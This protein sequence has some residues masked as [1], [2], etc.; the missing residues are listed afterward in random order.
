MN[1]ENFS[2][3]GFG[4]NLLLLK[5]INMG[6]TN[7]KL[8]PYV[9]FK[10]NLGNLNN[11]NLVLSF[12]KNNI[13][14]FNTFKKGYIGKVLYS[15]K[16]PPQK[17]YYKA[18]SKF[19]ITQHG[20]F[21]NF[22]IGKLERNALD[23]K[24]FSKIL[25]RKS[26]KYLT[27]ANVDPSGE[28]NR[29]AFPH[30]WGVANTGILRGPYNIYSTPSINDPIINS[31]VD[32]N[33]FMALPSGAFLNYAIYPQSF[34]IYGYPKYNYP[35]Y[36]VP[37]TVNSFAGGP[38]GHMEGLLVLSTGNSQNKR[39][40][41]ISPHGVRRK[42][43]NTVVENIETIPSKQQKDIEVRVE[44][45]WM[46]AAYGSGNSRWVA[47]GRTRYGG[48]TTDVA[49]SQNGKNWQI[50]TEVL[51][52]IAQWENIAYGTGRWVTLPSN[53]NVS[54]AKGATS[55]NGQNW[56]EIDINGTNNGTYFPM[57]QFKDIVFNGINRW[58]IL[59]RDSSD[60][61]LTSTDGV[62]WSGNAALPTSAGQNDYRALAYGNG[63]WVTL[64]NAG[65]N[66]YSPANGAI[67][68]D[69]I[70][71]ESFPL[72][73]NLQ[74]R[75][76]EFGSGRFVSVPYYGSQF[77]TSTDGSEWSIVNVP[78]N[79]SWGGLT[80]NGQEWIA[81]P[82]S[83][84]SVSGLKSTN[85]LNWSGFKLVDKPTSKYWNAIKS[86]PG[87]ETTILFGNDYIRRLSAPSFQYL[88][89]VSGMALWGLDVNSLYFNNGN[90][91]TNGFVKLTNAERS[92]LNAETVQGLQFILTPGFNINVNYQTLI[93]DLNNSID[94]I[95]RYSGSGLLDTLYT[96]FSGF[97]SGSGA[98][99]AQEELDSLITTR[100]EII[101]LSGDNSC[102][103]INPADPA[104][105]AYSGNSGSFFLTDFNS[106]IPYNHYKV[107]NYL[108]QE[109]PIKDTW[110]YKIYS[111][112]YTSGNGR[113]LF[114][115]GTWNGIIP[116]GTNLYIE[117]ISTNNV[118]GTT[119]TEFLITYTGYG[120]ND[121]IDSSAKMFIHGEYNKSVK[122]FHSISYNSYY[123][124]HWKNMLKFQKWKRNQYSANYIYSA[125]TPS[126]RQDRIRS[127]IT[128]QVRD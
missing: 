24:F 16:Q 88:K 72:I 115:T 3:L 33:R 6:N 57:N 99:Y 41:Y 28:Y 56:S 52:H 18:I 102:T 15:D 13:F 12:I 107:T 53:H 100:D 55:L 112:V 119:N 121:D 44:G 42:L 114:N 95:Y 1:Q 60:R 117:Y 108:K 113:K 21:E 19:F 109:T 32:K 25:K 75:Y 82:Q 54:F 36:V 97:A 69:G 47:V 94:L 116:S 110:F 38:N 5:N 14:Y 17:T 85:G 35:T 4:G 80:F 8:E 39:I 64:N 70:N 86:N 106:F 10:D 101:N 9:L 74:S 59:G 48:S 30:K 66:F 127:F 111:G 104:S 87:N 2:R 79:T 51:P 23:A 11:P 125:Y 81:I 122:S 7:F 26:I 67:S 29:F 120:T 20:E 93:S 98:Y 43:Y 96:G 50:L 34:F 103:Y 49:I 31:L 68:T 58:V 77:A 123:D 62:N 61:T 40:V 22:N 37:H 71:W 78:M 76:L 92:G 46:N 89:F 83:S 90:V 118:V 27:Y 126:R 91:F 65:G 128:G 84:S 105:C 124:A 63:K 73:G 45:Q